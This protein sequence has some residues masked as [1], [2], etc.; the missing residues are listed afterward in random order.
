MLSWF[1]LRLCVQEVSLRRCTKLTD[2]GIAA[3]VLS[4]KLRSL[5]VSG[6]SHVGPASLKSLATSCTYAHLPLHVPSDSP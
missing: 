3:L 6:I 2:V 4:G 5:N 1:V